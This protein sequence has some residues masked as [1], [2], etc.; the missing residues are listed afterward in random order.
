MKKFI[1]TITFIFTLL[2]VFSIKNSAKSEITLNAS[3]DNVEKDEEITITADIENEEIAAYTL[4]IYFD[5]E[6]VECTSKLDNMNII[7][8]K[9]IYTWFSDTG[10][11]KNMEELIKV[12]FKSKQ[13]GITSF[14]LI[15]EVYKANGEK[16]DIKYG[17]EEVKI[18]AKEDG[19]DK[20]L[21]VNNEDSNDASLEIMRVNREG[22]NPDFNKDI[23]EYYLIVD[24]SVDKLD[25]T[26]IASNKE[27]DVKITGN[28]NLKMGL[29]KIKILV[30]SEDKT[31]N[32]EYVINV[33]KTKN[34]NE[35]EADLENLAIENYELSPEFDRNITNYSAE[36]SND[37]EKLN[38]LAIPSD[39]KAK[40]EVEGNEK[41]DIGKNEITVIVTAQDGIT[42][43][44]YYINVKRRNNEEE[45][46]FLKEQ[47]NNMEEANIV[48]EKMNVDNGNDKEIENVKNVNKSMEEEKKD[49]KVVDKGIT[50]VGSVL[51]LIVL[52]IG[53]IRIKRKRI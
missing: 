14:Y 28:E 40:V 13:D 52:G 25:I 19:N 20:D 11:N 53:V 42:S 6:K 4:W 49:T 31:Q 3:E 37:T 48:M 32:K 12:N 22:I 16:L 18:G 9:I 34:Q 35:A 36:V 39:I 15:G 10:V 46:V 47:Q 21:N 43:K 50:I 38:V 27:A 8:D 7:G 23:K 33:T 26:A 2:T 24:E 41:I 44:R 30:T 51:F 29:N 45:N 1:I 17:C 5:S